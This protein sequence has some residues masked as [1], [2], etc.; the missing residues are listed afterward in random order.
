MFPQKAFELKPILPNLTK[1]TGTLVPK[2]LASAENWLN[3]Q[4][5]TPFVLIL[6][7]P[8]EPKGNTVADNVILE[9]MGS[10]SQSFI[11]GEK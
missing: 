3:C 11:Y 1:T 7:I 10:R 2:S 8:I 9:T 5:K 4:E 6:T